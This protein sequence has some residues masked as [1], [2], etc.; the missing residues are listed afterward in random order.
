MGSERIDVRYK[1]VVSYNLLGNEKEN[2]N[3]RMDLSQVL[4]QAK[5]PRIANKSACL[6]QRVKKCKGGL[7]LYFPSDIVTKY[8]SYNGISGDCNST[9][10]M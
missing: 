9:K 4:V 7:S 8:Q 6:G 2:E 5:A 1:D 3:K 10:E